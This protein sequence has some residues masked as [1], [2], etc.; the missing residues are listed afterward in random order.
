VEI[1]IAKCCLGSVKQVRETFQHS[2]RYLGSRSHHWKFFLLT[3]V[4]L[5][6]I[7]IVNTVNT[8]C[9][10]RTSFNNFSLYCVFCRCVPT[11]KT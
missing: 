3:F 6:I 7:M 2:K 9:F 5:I 8:Y 11:S 10:L 1:E 4:T